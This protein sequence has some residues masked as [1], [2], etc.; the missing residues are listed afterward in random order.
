MHLA[1]QHSCAGFRTI[2]APALNGVPHPQTQFAPPEPSRI[3]HEFVGSPDAAMPITT[4]V[5][6]TPRGS[7]IR[8]GRGA[9]SP[10]E[11][12][13]TRCRIPALNLP[14]R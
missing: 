2:S 8:V 11:W 1:R 3:V 6:K 14:L 12:T 5:L 4:A 13:P 9:I 10:P 7:D